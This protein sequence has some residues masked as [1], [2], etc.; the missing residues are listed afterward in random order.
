L[1]YRTN[2]GEFTEIDW[3]GKVLRTLRFVNAGRVLANPS[4]R[5]LLIW[6]E[7]FDSAARPLG[8]VNIGSND[9]RDAAWSSSGDSLCLI[10]SGPNQGPNSGGLGLFV[11]GPSQA[12]KQIATVGNSLSTP[13]IAACDPT[14]GR[15]VVVNATKGSVLGGSPFTEILGL[16]VFSFPSGKLI[17]SL[18]YGPHTNSTEADGVVASQDGLYLAENRGDGS[19]IRDLSTGRI[20]QTLKGV[21]TLAFSGEANS[22]LLAART[23]QGHAE[24]LQWTFGRV[25]WQSASVAQWASYHTKQAEVV[26]GVVDA[27]GG[28]LDLVAVAS[29]GTS[30]VLAQ[31]V[32][33][34]AI[35]PCPG[36]NVY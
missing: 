25:V 27:N 35:C 10:A 18:D 5:V 21:S 33:A 12:F 3:S 32:D 6:P 7:M 13:S 36:A 2:P 9:M 24:V 15:V 30:R 8:A 14:H 4:G 34:A 26:F 19:E 23:A 20:V 28:L 11:G 1:Y 22:S 31:N 16:R 17:Y 29:D